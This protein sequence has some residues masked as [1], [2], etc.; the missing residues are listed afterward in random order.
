MVATKFKKKDF[1]KY[2]FPTDESIY[3]A[4]KFKAM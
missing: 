3:I 4:K 2:V 1:K